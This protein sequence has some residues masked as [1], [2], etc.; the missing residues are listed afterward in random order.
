M[1]GLPALIEEDVKLLDGALDDLLRKSEATAALVIDKGGPL[2][3]QR[4]AVDGFDTT[5]ISALAAG[6]FCAT[7]A[8]AERMNE[9][10]FASI[11]QQGEHHS[12]LFCNIDENVLLIVIFKAK[13]S[14][15]IVKYYA[16][17]TVHRIMTQLQKAQ[18][19]D[20][21]TSVDLVSLNVL[22]STNIFRKT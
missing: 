14:V 7:Q 5:T 21:D 15:G 17:E 8:I 18:K 13:L 9:T 6:S 12:L 10:N 1:P 19:R 2:I 22:D 3:N 4:G 11:Y 16:A 20:P